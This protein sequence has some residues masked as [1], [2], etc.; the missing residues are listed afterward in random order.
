MRV[1]VVAIIV[2]LFN[3]PF[4]Y[5]RENVKRFSVQ[6]I[7]AIHL[8][9]PFIIL[10]RIYSDIGFRLYTY[11]ILIAAFIIGQLTGSKFYKQRRNSGYEPI[12]SCLLMDVV[13]HNKT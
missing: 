8:P 2:L 13:R 6:W 11:P 9:I 3:I 7:L 4:G 1:F 5:W 10:L 12:S